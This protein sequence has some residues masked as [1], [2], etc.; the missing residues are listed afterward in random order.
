MEIPFVGG[1]YAGRS[2]VL[3]AQ[4]CTNLFPVVDPT[5]GKKV[6]AL[7]GTSGC[8]AF[9]DLSVER[10]VRGMYV[11]ENLIY[12]VCGSY[13]KTV[14][15]AGAVVALGEI[16]T[17]TGNVSMSDNGLQ[18]I[19]VD[20]TAD[21][22]LVEGG[23][24]TAISDGDFP[25]SSTVTFQDGYFIVTETAS[26]RIW[27]SGLYDGDSWDALDYATAEARPDD[28]VTVKSSSRELWVLGKESTEVYYN[29]GD[30]DFPFERLPGAFLELGIGAQDSLAKGDLSL[31]WLTD[32]VELVRSKGYSA[33]KVSTETVEYQW[34]LYERID[35]A[36]G[37]FYTE[38]G[39]KFYQITFPT[40]N[41]TWVYDVATGFLHERKSYQAA[42]TPPGRHRANCHVWFDNKNIVG[43]YENG[44][45]YELDMDTFTDNGQ[46]IRRVRAAQSISEERLNIFYHRFEVEFE[47]GVGMVV[48][49]GV[50]P[51]AVLDW[52][53][54][55]AKTWS[56]ELWADIGRIGEYQARVKWNR[57]GRARSRVFRVVISD[58][59]KVVIVAAYIDAEAGDA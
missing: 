25:A 22:Y 58:P 20:G 47:A 11:F 59:V 12:V 5:A 48:G 37:F 4:E 18:V 19:I 45:L 8:K 51:Q 31:W 23:V 28:V 15:A 44:K 56:N 6:R 17:A 36:K 2:L 29:S 54:D 40:A 42:V 16:S 46:M 55:G 26:G 34:S 32:Q 21:G 30:A 33:Q 14:N 24:L 41:K 10:A 27:V 50:N 57:L 53:D 1:S 9:A 13:V 38:A 39:H 52:S 35:D 7:Y 3:N 43:D 49:A